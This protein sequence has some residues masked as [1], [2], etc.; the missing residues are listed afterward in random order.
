VVAAIAVALVVVQPAEEAADR[1]EAAQEP[2]PEAAAAQ[3][4]EVA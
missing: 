4:A 1:I 2:A 3:A